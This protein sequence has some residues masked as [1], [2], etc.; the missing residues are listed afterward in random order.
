MAFCLAQ[1]DDHLGR[2]VF[3][4]SQKF[5]VDGTEYLGVINSPDLSQTL[6]IGGLEEKIEYNL[7]VQTSLFPKEKAKEG[8]IVTIPRPQGAYA[9]SALSVDM[10]ILTVKISPDNVMFT[11]GLSFAKRRPI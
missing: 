7:Y 8:T 3:D 11:F 5:K 10:R 6:E 9:D 4:L 1:F 2:C